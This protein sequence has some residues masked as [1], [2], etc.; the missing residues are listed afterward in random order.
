MYVATVGFRG[1]LRPTDKFTKGEA[2]RVVL[3]GYGNETVVMELQRNGQLI[4][5]DEVK[6]PPPRVYERDVG[7]E[8]QNNGGFIAPAHR[9]ELVQTGNEII[10]TLKPLPLGSYQVTVKLNGLAVETARFSV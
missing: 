3:H 1:K 8:F 5:S 7:V 6:V 4:S 10:Y 2:P 9:R